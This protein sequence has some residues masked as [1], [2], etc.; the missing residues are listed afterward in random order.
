[1][2]IGLGNILFERLLHKRY[3]LIDSFLVVTV[4]IERGTL[5]RRLRKL[6]KIAFSLQL[7]LILQRLCLITLVKHLE[8]SFIGVSHLL[9]HL[10]WIAE[11]L[12]VV[13]ADVF[14]V[15]HVKSFL[16]FIIIIWFFQRTKN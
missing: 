6:S 4:E 10:K 3:A 15:L 12:C 13:L 16:V 7:A 2:C 14:S 1:M 8:G 5:C 11:A 9:T